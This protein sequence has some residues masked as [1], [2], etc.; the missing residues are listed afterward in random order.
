MV[1]QVRLNLFLKSAFEALKISWASSK[2]A[3]AGSLLMAS[4]GAC[5]VSSKLYMLASRFS[6]SSPLPSTLA[7]EFS[8]TLIVDRFEGFVLGLSPLQTDTV[9]HEG[10]ESKGNCC[11]CDC[12][13]LGPIHH[14]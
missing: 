8:D 7:D 10:S 11:G 4:P 3:L 12:N 2:A 6:S 5:P 13:D 14:S 1:F 9:E